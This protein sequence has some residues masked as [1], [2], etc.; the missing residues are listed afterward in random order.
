MFP[1]GIFLNF[2][3]AYHRGGHLDLTVGCFGY[4]KTTI[5]KNISIDSRSIRFDRT[6]PSFTKLIP[7]F[8]NDSPE[9]IANMDMGFPSVFGLF[10]QS[11]F[12]VEC[13][14][15]HY[16]N[17]CCSITGLIGCIGSIAMICFSRCH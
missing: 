12:L 10:S 3:G 9:V 14:H 7:D 4:V 2:F 5:H 11:A 1:G 8:V 17:A 16:F 15:A 13:Y 6:E